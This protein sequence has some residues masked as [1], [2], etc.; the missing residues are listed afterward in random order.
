MAKVLTRGSRILNKK[1]PNIKQ[2]NTEGDLKKFIKKKFIKN[3][4]KLLKSRGKNFL[5]QKNKRK[6]NDIG[7][8]SLFLDERIAYKMI[9]TSFLGKGYCLAKKPVLQASHTF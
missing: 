4:N 1:W 8:S 5:F 6:I 7:H 3:I 9:R 2:E